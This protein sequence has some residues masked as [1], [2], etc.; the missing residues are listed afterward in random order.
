M[1]PSQVAAYSRGNP[2]IME[3]TYLDLYTAASTHLNA[4]EEGTA[5]KRIVQNRSNINDRDLERMRFMIKPVRTGLGYGQTPDAF[6]IYEV[7]GDGVQMSPWAHNVPV[8]ELWG[9]Y[10]IDSNPGALE[11]ILRVHKKY[12]DLISRLNSGEAEAEEFTSLFRDAK[13]I[14]ERDEFEAYWLN[15]NPREREEWLPFLDERAR[16]AI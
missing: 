3:A 7:S 16:E 15:A 13:R 10:V 11:D 2:E 8:D 5:F 14:D 4:H 9:A 1:Y 12:D 6:D